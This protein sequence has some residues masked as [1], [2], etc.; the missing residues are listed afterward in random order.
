MCSL[1]S[2]SLSVPVYKMGA[3][4]NGPPPQHPERVSEENKQG[5]ARLNPGLP[6]TGP[7]SADAEDGE[8]EPG[9]TV[10]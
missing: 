8:R 4:T 1:A 3:R 10:S 2:L 6:G 7:A 5:E 9:D